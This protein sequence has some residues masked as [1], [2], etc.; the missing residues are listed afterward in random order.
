MRRLCAILLLIPATCVSAPPEPAP[1]RGE[2]RHHPY[3]EPAC[4]AESKQQ[5]EAWWRLAG[6]M[7]FVDP[8]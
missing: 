2:P 3:W 8:Q 4:D 7:A 1:V 5:A 6:R